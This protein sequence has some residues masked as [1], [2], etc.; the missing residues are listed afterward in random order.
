MN[1]VK[2]TKDMTIGTKI[3]TMK[4]AGW[5]TKEVYGRYY[6]VLK[7]NI[8]YYNDELDEEIIY[9]EE[10]IV[11][12]ATVFLKGAYNIKARYVAI[13]RKNYSQWVE[14]AVDYYDIMENRRK[15]FYLVDSNTI[16][17]DRLFEIVY[18]AISINI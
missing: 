5:E 14:I 3:E 1:K 17:H 13:F 2:Y 18:D 16:L 10:E 6:F 7:F 11:E 9:D 12:R 4:E 8:D 15:Y